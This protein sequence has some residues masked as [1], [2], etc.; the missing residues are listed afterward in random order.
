MIKKISYALF[1]VAIA[2]GVALSQDAAPAAAKKGPA[3]PTLLQPQMEP[4]GG[5]AK[6]GDMGIKPEAKW[7]A[8]TVG[9]SVDGK[10][11]N[12]REV[13]VEGEIVDLS[14]YLQVGKHGDKHSACGKKCIAAGQPIGLVTKEGVVYLLMDEEHDPR[15][16]GQTTF[17]KAAGD[18]FAKVMTV[19][20]TQTAINGIKSIYVQ[21]FVTK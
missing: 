21:G 18:N 16:D 14:C 7:S 5:W 6:G 2:S 9:A 20:G 15:R 19:T 12:G 1:A 11:L 8:T 10:P 13:S 17:R 4:T 3:G